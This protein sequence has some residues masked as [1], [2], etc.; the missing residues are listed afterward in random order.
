M[1]GIETDYLVVGTGAAGMAFTDALIAESEA[2][3]VMVDRRHRPGGHWN[4]AYPFVRLHTPSSYYG[5]NSRV[6]GRDAIDTVGPN[7]GLYERATAA[8]ILDYFGRVLDEHFLPS[9]QVRAFGMSE[10]L[11]ED[12]SGDHHLVPRLTGETTT[13]RVRRK[14]VDVADASSGFTVIG[15]GKTAMDACTWLLD[16]GVDPGGIR[17]IQPREAWLLDRAFNQPGTSW[18]R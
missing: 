17:W 2:S 10:Y 15:A 16:N 18:A 6:L 3:V 9:G 13:V 5:V 14:L 12:P 8:E 7:A 11:G 4:D 1:T